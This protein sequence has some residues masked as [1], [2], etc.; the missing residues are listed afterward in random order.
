MLGVI[1]RLKLLNFVQIFVS[2]AV[3]AVIVTIK[4]SNCID[5]LVARDLMD[6]QAENGKVNVVLHV[7]ALAICPKCN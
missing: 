4:R 5:L 1:P 7:I 2:T 3:S 6:Q